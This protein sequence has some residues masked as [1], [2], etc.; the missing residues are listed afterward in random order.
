MDKRIK[1]LCSIDSIP[2][3]EQ[4]GFLP[5]WNTTRYLFKLLSTLHETRER[6]LTA[7]L[8]CIDFQKAFDSVPHECLIVK[9][10]KLGISGNL[11]NLIDN[12]LSLRS[13]RLK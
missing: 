6:K 7:F 5:V 4:G 8:L 10:N 9:F 2:D 3:E 1:E 11:L 12:M 13:V